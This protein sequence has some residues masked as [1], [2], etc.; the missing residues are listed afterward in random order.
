MI[1]IAFRLSGYVC[2]TD[3]EQW[4]EE[5]K[6]NVENYCILDEFVYRMT[7]IIKR[8]VG[9]KQLRCYLNEQTH[10]ISSFEMTF[11]LLDNKV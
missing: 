9:G 11:I 1:L 5:A 8:R 10:Q 3:I 6:V 4:V 2:L 7:V